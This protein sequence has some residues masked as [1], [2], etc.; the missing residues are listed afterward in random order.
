MQNSIRTIFIGS[1][2]A[3]SV[4]LLGLLTFINVSQQSGN[5]EEELGRLLE[6]KSESIA[7]QF[8]NRV[9]KVSGKTDA[10]AM[11]MSSMDA[12][13]NMDYA[14]GLVRNLVASDEIIYGSG[15]WFAPNA[16]PE[17]KWFGPY[18]SKDD[19]GKISMTMDYSTEEYNY[20]QFGWYKASIQG[21]K[22]VFWDEPAYDDV[23]KT[24]MMS[25][26][27]PIRHNG[28]IVGVVTVDI[29][30]TDLENYIRDIKIGEHGYAFLVS[31]SGLYIAS[32]D[33][34]KNMKEKIQESTNPELARVGQQIIGLTEPTQF[35][36][37]AFGEDSYIT[38]LP[39]GNTNLKLVL[40]APKAD[41]SGPIHQAAITS[42]LLSLVVIVVLCLAIYFIFARRVGTP[43][44]QLMQDAERI[45]NGDLSTEV[46]AA[47]E[48]ELGQLA[49]SLNKMA[50]EIRKIILQVSK[51]AEQL[52][53]ASEELYATADQSMHSMD[54]IAGSVSGVSDGA[55]KQEG[56]I[57]DAANSVETINTSISSV[58]GLVHAA[59]DG[60]AQSIK[61]MNENQASMKETVT[62]MN[63]I[64]SRING[65]QE[66]IIELGKHSDEIQQIVGTITSISEQT[67]LLALNAAIEAARAGEHGRGF[68][69]VAEEVRKL[70]EQSRQAAEQ[71]AQLIG[72]SASFTQKAVTEMQSSTEAVHKGTEAFDMTNQ[73]FAQL[74][75]HIEK[76]SE[77]VKE[78]SEG[79]A[80][81]A[82]ENSG[83]LHGTEELKL[84]G[85]NT[86][87]EAEDI[88]HSILGQQSAQKDITAASQSL[89]QL[90]QDL[91]K[92]IGHFNV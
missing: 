46:V 57:L 74:V 37:D 38:A 36:T 75:T 69:V 25:S 67:N 43:I 83:V 26:S 48:D 68:A 32:P 39:I 59:L 6:A 87:R 55:K 61:A 40:V 58:N 14:Y 23:S 33:A 34:N 45:A 17:Q 51:M 70:A 2:I 89:S 18:F 64:S 63:Q 30:M 16:Y 12:G 84:I 3:L 1:V 65:A 91:Q 42:A 76:M 90:A 8:N 15:I 56:H 73:L 29:G 4:V 10:L 21:P 77:D 50:E 62:Q 35:S 13:Y 49:Q 20:P 53:A 60:T 11:A 24:S 72:Q 82:H 27:A 79:V 7:Q 52:S 19:S 28:Q 81:I 41:Y 71:V 78:I 47:N 85:L 66:A 5:M 92:L 9:T 88:S 54:Q 86:T 31:Q 22:E 80:R 44:R